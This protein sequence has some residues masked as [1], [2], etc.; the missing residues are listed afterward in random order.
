[1]AT[2]IGHSILGLAFAL[3]PSTR[4]SLHHLKLRYWLLLVVIAANFADL[5]FLPGLI[6]GDINLYH[7]GIS[8][9]FFAALLFA[10]CST[11]LLRNRLNNMS[12]QIATLSFIAYSSHLF[13]DMLGQDTR[14]PYGIPL[15]WPI[16]HEYFISPVILFP[17][18]KHGVPGDSISAFLQQFF[19][20]STLQGLSTE[21][22]LTTPLL[23]AVYF[24][25][26]RKNKNT[27]IDIMKER[28]L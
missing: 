15:F 17:G 12:W 27:R 4:R 9:S 28:E 22:F 25:S 23:V 8:H 13:A 6:V 7:H 26:R 20:M 24:L 5:D 19:S 11:L 2:P 18:V 1:M 16:S 3:L 21:I 10:L 14:A